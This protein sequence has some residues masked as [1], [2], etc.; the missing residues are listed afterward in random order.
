[1]ALIKCPECGAEISDKADKCIKCGCPLKFN[2]KKRIITQLFWEL[3][4]HYC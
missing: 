2:V 3:L 1:M 4:S